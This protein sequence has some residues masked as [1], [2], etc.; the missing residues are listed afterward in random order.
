[1]LALEVNLHSSVFRVLLGFPETGHDIG[2][3]EGVFSSDQQDVVHKVPGCLGSSQL[4]HRGCNCKLRM[5]LLAHGGL[6]PF[7]VDYHF[8]FFFFFFLLKYEN[9]PA[10]PCS[11]SC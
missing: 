7:L 4:V 1:M 3:K 11:Q 8:P 6:N 5:L 2:F 10:P 9:S